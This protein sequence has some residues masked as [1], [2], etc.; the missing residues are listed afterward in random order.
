MQVKCKYTLGSDLPPKA[1]KGKGFKSTNF[2]LEIGA[3]Y[4]VYSI[5][6]INGVVRYLT[7]DRWQTVPFWYPAELYT[8]E[9]PLLPPGWYFK[10]FFPPTCVGVEA[11]WGY[12]EMIFDSQHFND[13]IEREDEAVRT[14]IK[15]KEE[16]DSWNE[17]QPG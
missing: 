8:I 1:L 15:R 12:K 10:Y 13:L 9:D 3:L 4:S 14:F 5:V 7:L 2:N 6:L 16:I 17:A 11:L